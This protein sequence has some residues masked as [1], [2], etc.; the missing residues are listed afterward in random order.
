MK[1]VALILLADGREKTV[2][3]LQINA[4]NLPNTSTEGRFRVFL[5]GNARQ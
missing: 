4:I 5:S 1:K 3:R 2:M